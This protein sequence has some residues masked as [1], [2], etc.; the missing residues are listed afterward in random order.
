MPK[1]YRVTVGGP[2]LRDGALRRLREGVEL[3]DGR[4]RCRREVRRINGHELELTLR[5]G[6]KR[7]V[8]RM[9]DAVG[10]PVR[11][12]RARA[13]SA[14]CRSGGCARAQSRRLTPA[15]VERLRAAADEPRVA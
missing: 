9:C 10:H 4:D 8:R 7:Q 2:A 12:L 5:E 3:E 13:R 15:E 14:R 1:T 11:E 6:R